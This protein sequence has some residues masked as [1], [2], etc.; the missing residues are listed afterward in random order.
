MNKFNCFGLRIVLWI[1]IGICGFGALPSH[2]A[3]PTTPFPVIEQVRNKVQI[4]GVVVDT[5]GEV[6]IGATVQEKGNGN[7]TITDSDGKFMISTSSDAV[8]VFSYISYESKEIALK[9]E[10]NLRVVLENYSEKLDEI[11]VVGYG[12]QKKINLSG[13]VDQ[14]SSAQLEQRPIVNLSKG[15]QGMVPNL[16]IDFTSGEPGQAARINIRGEASINGGSPLILIDGVASDA[17][18]MNRLLPED[19]ESLSVL[20]DA[21]S[22]A[23]YG[24]RAAFGVILITT[25][26]GK[27]ERIQVSY[28]NNFSWKRPS[29]LTDKTSDPY[30]YLKLKNIAVLNTPWSSG[31]VTNDER[32]EWARQRSDNPNGTEAIRLNPLD[33]TQWEYMGNRNWTNYFLDKNTFSNTHQ[34]SISGATDKTKF[35]LSGG[36]DD[37]DGVFSGVVKND[38]YIRYSMRGKVNYKI[39][40]WLTVS[41]NTSFVSTTRKKPSYYNLS[42]FYDAEPHNVDVNTDGTWANTE[43]GE[44]LAQLVD[45]G[46]EKTV[47]DRI[48]SIFSAEMEFWKRMLLLNANFTFVKGNENYDWYKNK[49]RIGFG[50]GDI[51][52]QGTSRAYKS[53]TSD[54]Y[55]V[56]DLYATFNKMF[57]KHSVTG[58]VGFN[59]EYSR[60][61][62]FTADRY[63]IISTSLPSIGLASGEQYVGESYKDWAIR[64]VFFR[65]NYTYDNRYIFEVNGRYDGTSRFPKN[66]RFGFFPS[67]SVAWRIDSE[68][69]FESIRTIVPQL[70]LRAS[71]GSLGNQLVSEYGYIP[72]MSSSLGG[73]LIDGKLQQTVTSPGLVSPNY[74]WEQVRTLNAGIDLGLNNNKL[75]ASF[76]IYRRDTKG[77]LTLGKE[78]PGV[79]GKT[80]PKENAAD[81]KTNGWELS[82]AYKDAFQL[83]GKPF[84]WGTRF[85]LSDNRSWI[86]KFDNSNKNLSQYYEGQELGEIWGLQNDGLFSSK[87]EIAALDETEII[88]WGALEIVEGWPKYKDLN[89]DKRITKG[90][91]VDNPGDLSIIG[92][93]SPR[94]RFGFNLNAE[95]NGFDMSAFLQGI[96]K[97]DYY[98][99][100]YLYWSF[101]QQPYTGGQVHAFDFYRPTTDNEIE[102][103]KHSQSYINAGLANQNL[104]AKYPVFQAWLAD[105]NLGTGINAM[106]LAIPQTNYLLNGA[107]LR[108]KNITVGYTLPAAIT[109][110]ARISK[111]RIYVSGDNLFE[112]SALK[113]YFDPE[114]VTNEDSF[115]YVYPFNRQYSFG[116]NATF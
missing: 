23:I 40:D 69:F 49:Y 16:N 12:V 21:S 98:P 79:L 112:W 102:M 97:R 45:G 94:F 109:K 28:N 1:F 3:E 75:T 74:T 34:V 111:I 110:K 9:G 32:L 35:Y 33:E 42:A 4:S 106:G 24:A 61:N 107:Y 18:E 13:S 55:T 39:W 2:A 89:N 30:I 20:K 76:D 6:L 11:V 56:L 91:T 27:G 47:Y 38:K 65:A 85:V 26:Q 105:K 46:E 80:E 31:H 83:K 78:L 57:N 71:Y 44:A 52:E 96:A 59:Q 116:I 88:P 62:N 10:T 100:S 68:P 67:G 14:I 51:R 60:W 104:D 19:I 115:G 64:G 87:D 8:L 82:V 22:A 50:P 36:I 72:S 103:A 66:K 63:D 99:V 41:N 113:K 108:I 86:T 77:M 25:K 58:I 43:L 92:N 15:L 73:Y 114:S 53:N 81:M 17:E 70:K 5:S 29:S 90:T 37:E 95:W 101:Y 84:N 93:S 54:F 7:G 48:Q